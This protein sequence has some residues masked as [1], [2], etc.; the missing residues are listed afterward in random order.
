[1]KLVNDWK[2]A[3]KWYSVNSNILAGALVGAWLALPD[4]MQDSF[5]PWELKAAALTLIVLSIGGRLID[6]GKKE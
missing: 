2:S 5:E 3:W 4:K 6:Q 1:M